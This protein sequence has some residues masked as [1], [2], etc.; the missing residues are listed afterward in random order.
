MKRDE[1]YPARG[2]CEGIDPTPVNV[3]FGRRE[4]HADGAKVRPGDN[5]L[6]V[7]AVIT[8]DLS[9]ISFVSNKKRTITQERVKLGVI[10]TQQQRPSETGSCDNN[11]LLHQH[12]TEPTD[13]LLTRSRKQNIIATTPFSLTICHPL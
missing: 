13:P 7:I 1:Q 9:T 2:Q 4:Q 8:C 10:P 3:L 5:G 12:G 6:N 11:K